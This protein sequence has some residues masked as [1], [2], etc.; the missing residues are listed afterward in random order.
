MNTITINNRKIGKEFPP[1]IIA[2]LSANHN[3]KIERAFESIK[4]AK[5][6]GADAI[7]I[8]TYTADTMTIDCDKEEFQIHGGLWDGYKLYDLYKWAETPFEWHKE[9]FDYANEI[10]ITLFSTPFDETA[11]DLLENLNAPA[12]KVASFE[13][14]DL[15]LIRYIASTKKPMI[16]STGMANYQ[17]ILEMVD[18]A[19]SG[20]CKDLILLHCI[21]SY[22][23]P[24]EQSN[25]LTIPD[26]RDK[27]GVQI[28]LS[29]HTLTNTASITS[30]ALGATVIEK[31]F[32]LDR[33]DKGPDSEF[34][35]MPLELNALCRETKDAWLALGVAS[36]DRKPAEEANVVFRRSLYFV[37]DLRAG[38]TI[39]KGDFRRIR[40][41]YGLAPKYA[42][43]IIGKKLKQDVSVGT[44]VKWELL[45]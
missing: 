36:Y 17:E 37:K 45:A 6:S 20:G 10:G 3:G 15:P 38:D 30:I 25:L 31:H 8:Q 34:S 33:A 22:P 23:A 1:Y 16:M 9:I 5:E 40:P 35:I 42:E 11:V 28:G 26:L 4:S 29:D 43:E 7:K 14:T 18:A 41:G 27:F 24:I 19:R 12:Y 21:S 32:I 44:A 39:T 2:E 13:A